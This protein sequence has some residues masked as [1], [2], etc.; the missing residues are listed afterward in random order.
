MGGEGVKPT[1]N[2]V[3]CRYLSPVSAIFLGGSMPKTKLIE[4]LKLL[5][6]TQRL[7]REVLDD[8]TRARVAELRKMSRSE[9]LALRN[10][11]DKLLRESR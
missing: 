8:V 11:A 10:E 3:K 2:A 6:G 9:L 4:S 7:V 5:S 1:E